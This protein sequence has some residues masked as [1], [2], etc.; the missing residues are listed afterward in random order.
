MTHEKKCHN[1]EKRK[2]HIE[3]KLPRL[4]NHHKIWF[5]G[6]WVG[7]VPVAHFTNQYQHISRNQPY[8]LL[9]GYLPCIQVG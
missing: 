3:T 7:V 1:Y 4:R 6:S 9:L 8:P 5:E 2:K